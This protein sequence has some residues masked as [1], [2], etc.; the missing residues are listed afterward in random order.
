M[1]TD[2]GGDALLDVDWSDTA[3]FRYLHKEEVVCAVAVERAAWMKI[4][5]WRD[6]AHL[7]YHLHYDYTSMMMMA[8]YTW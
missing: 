3:A 1:T 5:M 6:L 2:G 8:V 4:Q 7:H